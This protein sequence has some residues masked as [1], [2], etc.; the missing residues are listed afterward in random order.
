MVVI[1]ARAQPEV[2]VTQAH[3]P[4]RSH[5]AAEQRITVQHYVTR[6]ARVRNDARQSASVEIR[7]T[8]A[9]AGE[10][11][12][13]T[14]SECAAGVAHEHAIEVAVKSKRILRHYRKS[15]IVR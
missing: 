14:A 4:G 13:G 8:E 2:G 5:L 12:V 15:I 7:Q 11:S 3:A 9:V 10:R 6:Q 1:A